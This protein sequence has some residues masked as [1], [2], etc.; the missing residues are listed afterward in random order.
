MKTRF[1]Y[2]YNN[3]F[4]TASRFNA[5][6]DEDWK[7]KLDKDFSYSQGYYTATLDDSE[8]IVNPKDFYIFQYQGGHYSIRGTL[9]NREIEVFGGD[10]A[11]EDDYNLEYLEDTLDNWD[12]KLTVEQDKFRIF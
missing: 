3:Q 5:A 4:I 6:V 1:I 10:S 11:N 12:G 8:V 9:F 2:T 7:E